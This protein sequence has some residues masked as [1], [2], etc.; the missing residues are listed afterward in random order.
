MVVLLATVIDWGGSSG[1][2]AQPSWRAASRKY[3]K[4]GALVDMCLIKGIL[5]EILT[6]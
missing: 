4:F 2:L 6:R 3:C 1:V 5:D